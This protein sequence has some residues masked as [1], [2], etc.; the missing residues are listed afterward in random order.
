MP[1]LVIQ[2]FKKRDKHHV[3]NSTVHKKKSAYDFSCVGDVQPTKHEEMFRCV[4]Q[5]DRDD[6]TAVIT[7]TNFQEN[8][9]GQVTRGLRSDQHL[10]ALAMVYTSPVCVM[11][12]FLFRG[13]ANFQ[14]SLSVA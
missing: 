2:I 4:S 3:I 9:V 7:L 14:L 1:F 11:L 6:E 8:K 13:C 5:W 10:M 12:L